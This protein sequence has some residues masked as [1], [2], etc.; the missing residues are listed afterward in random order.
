MPALESYEFALIATGPED[1]T[2]ALLDRLYE[3]GCDDATASMRYGI[4]YLQFDRTAES[5]EAAILGA[6]ASVRK[7]DRSIHVVRVDECNLVTQSEIARRIG[8][9]RQSVNQY[10]A[11]QRGPGN[12]PRPECDLAEDTPVWAWCEVSQWFVEHG[13]LEPKDSWSAKVVHAVNTALEAKQQMKKHP[14]LVKR[15]NK[16]L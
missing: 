3:C 7:A 10:I 9:S 13:I 4:L 6:I 15:I 5:I 1:L 16:A 14:A 2:E 11:G 12:F 8:Q